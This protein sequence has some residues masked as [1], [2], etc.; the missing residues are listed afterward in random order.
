MA[1]E[2]ILDWRPFEY[3]TAEQFPDPKIR[4]VETLRLES[5]PDGRTRLSDI[6]TLEMAL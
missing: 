6:I 2:T 1:V 5:L 4:M 3:V